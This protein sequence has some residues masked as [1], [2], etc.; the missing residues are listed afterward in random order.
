MA[1]LLDPDLAGMLAIAMI[2][3]L[4][5]L[6]YSRDVESQ[7]DLTGSDICAQAGYNPWGLVWLFQDFQ[8]ADSN[9]VPQFLS[10]HPGNQER[11]GALKKHFREN[12]AVFGKFNPDPKSAKPIS[13]PKDTSEVFLH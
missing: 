7:A 12:P 8:N 3:R 6:G 13:L 9:Q 10:D 5:S 11:E 4:R 2:G 1:V